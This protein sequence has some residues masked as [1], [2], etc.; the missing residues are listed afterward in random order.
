[1]AANTVYV[2]GP[3][4]DVHDNEVVN[5]SVDKAGKVHVDSRQM[6]EDSVIPSVLAESELW[7]KIIDAGLV[8]DDCQ[9][10]ISRPEAALMADMISARLGISNKWKM[11]EKLWHR[12]NMRGDFNTALEQRK[13]LAFQEKLKKILG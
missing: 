1:M 5:L 11:F 9:P 2:Q 12:N 4:V 10:T 3:Y 6:S 8:D 7:Q 13:S